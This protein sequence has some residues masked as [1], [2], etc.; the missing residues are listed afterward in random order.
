M[1]EKDKEFIKRAEE[2]VNDSGC[3]YQDT[4]LDDLVREYKE[5]KK[6]SK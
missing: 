2:I 3:W 5:S 4:R 1:T 6:E